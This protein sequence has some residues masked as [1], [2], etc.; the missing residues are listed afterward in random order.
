M[1]L[2]VLNQEYTGVPDEALVK[3]IQVPLW[4]TYEVLLEQLTEQGMPGRRDPCPTFG[5]TT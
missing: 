3:K 2:V 1:D 5:R 4:L